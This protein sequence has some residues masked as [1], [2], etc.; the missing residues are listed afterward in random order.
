MQPAIASPATASTPTPLADL[1]EAAPEKPAIIDS[2]SGEDKVQQPVLKTPD[3]HTAPITLPLN[4]SKTEPTLAS[5]N[6]GDG[7]VAAAYGRLS[8]RI[9]RC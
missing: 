6:G 4:A 8:G 1:A 9:A 2:H 3:Q 5:A 7:P